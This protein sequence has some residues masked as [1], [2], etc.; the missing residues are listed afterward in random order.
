[1]MTRPNA[2]MNTGNNAQVVLTL[3]QRQECLA[4]MR[5]ALDGMAIVLPV[6][7]R[8]D[9]VVQAVGKSGAAVLIAEFGESSPQ[10]SIFEQLR[11]SFPDL[12]VIGVGS[13]S[14]QPSLLAA[15]RAQVV[16][17]VE[18][19]SSQEVLRHSVERILTEVRQRRQRTGR[20]VTMCGGIGAGCTTVACN[21]ASLIKG[22]HEN[23]S[24]LMLDFATPVGDAAVLMG[25]ATHI[26]FAEA[27]RNLSRCDR[28]YLNTAI[29][30]TPRGVGVLPLFHDV[31]ELRGLKLADAFQ[32]LVL[33]LSTYDV[34]VA[35]VGGA[36]SSELGQ[37]LLQSA[38]E[39]VVVVDQSVS[40]ILE[41]KKLAAQL[42][43]KL[44]SRFRAHL[45]VNHFEPILGVEAKDLADELGLP[46]LGSGILPERRIP[47]MQSMNGG[48]PVVEALPR[49]LFSG[50]LNAMTT[51]ILSHLWPEQISSLSALRQRSRISQWWSD[52]RNTR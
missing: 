48:K 17:Y 44:G 28:T 36:A 10:A 45:L 23:N 25:I 12:K 49:D 30:R 39:I 31:K 4:W 16:D 29:A 13:L 18:S 50:A 5:T 7:M 51:Q 15:M 14:D 27:V 19:E 41:G 34:V 24:V 38:D 3:C 37:Y 42:R 8:P 21:M 52:W 2:S 26:S 32:L 20:L 46:L 35:D 40:H 22:S 33:I 11:L 47:I 1:M 6:D 43:E 9:D